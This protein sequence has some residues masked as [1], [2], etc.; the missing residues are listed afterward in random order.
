MDLNKSVLPLK[1]R[2]KN[3]ETDLARKT[4]ELEDKNDQLNR[5]SAEIEMLKD[6]LLARNK[7]ITTLRETATKLG[8]QLQTKVKEVIEYKKKKR[9][10]KCFWKPNWNCYRK[11]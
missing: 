1:S 6:D 3:L 9:T 2:K 8:S 7:D 4:D 10:A 5:R 11:N